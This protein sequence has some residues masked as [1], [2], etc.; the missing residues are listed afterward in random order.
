MENDSFSILVKKN[1]ASGKHKQGSIF[2]DLV[3]N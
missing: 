3:E 2:E 1:M